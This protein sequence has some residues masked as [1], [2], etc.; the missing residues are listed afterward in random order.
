M[1]GRLCSIALKR[2]RMLC[3]PHDGM[4]MRAKYLSYCMYTSHIQRTYISTYLSIYLSILSIQL[5]TLPCT[6]QPHI[7]TS[8]TPPLL[9]PITVPLTHSSALITH[10]P[11]PTPPDHYT[12][13]IHHLTCSTLP[14]AQSAPLSTSTS[15]ST[16]ALRYYTTLHYTILSIVVLWYRTRTRTSRST[17][18]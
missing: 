18:E 5:S 10:L 9:P 13:L 1:V 17:S 15:T 3:V 12:Y 11:N 8:P 14:P 16:Y 4:R 2:E 6:S 7:P